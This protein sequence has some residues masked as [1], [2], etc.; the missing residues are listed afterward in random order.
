MSWGFT[1]QHT[2]VWNKKHFISY[3]IKKLLLNIRMTVSYWCWEIFSVDTT[4]SQFLWLQI[5]ESVRMMKVTYGHYTILSQAQ[6][7]ICHNINTNNQPF[8]C[9]SLKKKQ[10]NSIVPQS[11]NLF[12]GRKCWRNLNLW[13]KH[14]YVQDDFCRM[15]ISEFEIFPCRQINSF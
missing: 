7:K 3:K 1:T 5:L 4:T 14:K 15:I 8:T 2:Y 6:P 11:K 9:M 10:M 12:S 13:E